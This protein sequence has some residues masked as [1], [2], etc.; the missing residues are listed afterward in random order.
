MSTIADR[1]NDIIR[2]FISFSDSLVGDFD[3]LDVSIRLAEDCARLL[4]IAA[5]GLLLA[6][7]EDVLHLLAAT[8]EQARS[9][10]AFQLQRDEGPCLDCFHSGSSVS[11][12]ELASA[13][14][15]WPRF[16]SVALEQG[17]ASVHALPMKLWEEP[18][19][20]L[21]LF[22]NSPGDLD[23]Q[24]LNLAQA[25]AHVASIAILRES[26]APSR[27]MLIPGVQGAISSRNALEVAK[28]IVADAAGVDTDAAFLR[29]RQYGHA[30]GQSL[31]HLA[32]MFISVPPD[33]RRQ[34]LMDMGVVEDDGRDDQGDASPQ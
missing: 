20:A 26:H 31:S 12:P 8:S 14:D 32:R 15:R 30:H 4:D 33:A 18:L 11:V 16:V 10:E 22:G 23:E 3:V 25:L 2:S 24:D 21:G 13:A 6:D 34:L 28:G 5:V 29:L 9:L 27:S 17:F 7:A 19:G 1:E